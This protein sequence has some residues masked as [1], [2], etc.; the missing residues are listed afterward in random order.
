MAA[1]PPP[2]RARVLIT[3][4]MDWRNLGMDDPHATWKSDENP[5]GRLL[6]GAACGAPPLAR[7]GP[8]PRLL[9]ARAGVLGVDFSFTCL[10]TL[11]RAA[12][13]LD[14]GFFD[15]VVHLGLGVYGEN[16]T[17]LL[18]ESGAVNLRCPA[19]DAAGHKPPA[20]TLDGALD[21][22][23]SAELGV[24]GGGEGGDNSG[25]TGKD[26]TVLLPTAHQA[27]ALERAFSS[28]APGHPSGVAD[29]SA[30]PGGFVLEVAGARAENSYI[31]NETHWRGLDAA[32]LSAAARQAA[33]AS[34]A[35]AAVAAAVEAEEAV[36]VAV[37]RAGSPGGLRGTG[38]GGGTGNST[39]DAGTGGGGCEDG[40]HALRAAFF[41]HLP[42]PD[43]A[44]GDAGYGPL[45]AAVA[46]AVE[47]LVTAALVT[48]PQ[49]QGGRGAV[50]VRPAAQT[51]YSGN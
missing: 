18:V 14:Y 44:L 15:V 41:V 42:Y 40:T 26:A 2:R 39:T 50:A 25:G 5:S 48:T 29:G 17:T 31:C 9:R 47:R 19:A 46:A 24:L 45:A 38:G 22:F 11:W 27:A 1:P 37:E 51:Y 13:G 34:E 32:H 43:P 8:L 33:V 3:G 28:A 4:F 10:P 23:S 35:A 12:W 30:L 49:G 7:D 6:V 16:Y 36:E 20:L 21:R